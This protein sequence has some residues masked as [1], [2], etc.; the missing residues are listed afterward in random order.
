MRHKRTRHKTQGVAIRNTQYAKR[1]L[2][3]GLTGGYGSGKSTVLKIFKKLGARTIDVDV[4]VKEA[5][6]SG[7]PVYFKLV[8]L[9]KAQ[10]LLDKKGKVD[11]KAAARQA[12][13]NSAFRKRLEKTIHPWIFKKISL[14][15]TREKGILIIEIPLLF[16]TG[17]NKK[18][19]FV[20]TVDASPVKSITRLKKNSGL[21]SREWKARAKAQW[22]LKRKV[23]KSDFVI[24][25]NGTLSE[26][27]RQV[28]II[29]E[30]IKLMKIK[31]S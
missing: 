15:K 28:R 10:G 22:P 17:F 29:W 27:R 13:Q 23:N 26:T 3:V 25:N 1:A 16:E 12:F 6:R 8:R 9:A 21:S 18:T 20:I 7:S 24:R 19:D 14:A 4:W 31:R 2:L 5:W 11:F 30:I